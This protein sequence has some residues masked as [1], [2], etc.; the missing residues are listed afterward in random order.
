[1]KIRELVN[2][3]SLY[4][5]VLRCKMLRE[6]WP[7][8]C[9]Y[10]HSQCE[11]AW[12]QGTV[13]MIRYWRFWHVNRVETQ[14][15]EVS[16]L[17]G[18]SILSFWLV[19]FLW[20]VELADIYEPQRLSN[21]FQYQLHAMAALKTTRT[22]WRNI[23]TNLGSDAPIRCLFT[24]FLYRPKTN[25]VGSICNPKFQW[26]VAKENVCHNKEDWGLG[27]LRAQGSRVDST[28]YHV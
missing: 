26:N 25:T 15:W 11:D 22:Q 17:Q 23:E 28:R 20:M 2:N 7:K 6:T 19:Q 10:R 8:T 4:Q 1:M 12:K 21:F 13:Q 5:W 27:S 3:W 24:S 9:I 16:C 14:Y 18:W